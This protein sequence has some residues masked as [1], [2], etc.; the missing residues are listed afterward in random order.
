MPTIKQLP[1]ATAVGGND[2]IPVSQNG[3]TR[4]TTVS[5]LLSNTQRKRCGDDIWRLV[6]RV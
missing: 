6:T 1:A 5:T 2:L 4:G 3:L